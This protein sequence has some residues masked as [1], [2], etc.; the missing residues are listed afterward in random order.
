MS[1]S[2][3]SLTQRQDNLNKNSNQTLNEGFLKK[4][5]DEDLLQFCRYSHHQKEDWDLESIESTIES[6]IF[7]SSLIEFDGNREKYLILDDWLGENEQARINEELIFNEE[8]PEK[9]PFS[10]SFSSS[11][12]NLNNDFSD[13]YSSSCCWSP[14]SFYY[15]YNPSS[16]SSSFSSS[17]STSSLH[18][19]YTLNTFKKHPTHSQSKELATNQC[20]KNQQISAALSPF[21]KFRNHLLQ[22]RRRIG[23][24]QQRRKF[25]LR[26]AGTIRTSTNKC[27]NKVEKMKKINKKSTNT[28]NFAPIN[29]WQEELGIL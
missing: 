2:L 5:E 24:Q 4:D 23:Q 27:K 17:S 22:I 9:E 13:F 28:K 14:Q 18:D 26:N 1:F 15:S 8:L 16:S 3:I 25:S 20:Y 19:F 12:S 29:K 10:S 11:S 6:S 21:Q 7:S